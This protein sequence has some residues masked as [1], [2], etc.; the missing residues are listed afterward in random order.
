[1]EKIK[2]LAGE[3]GLDYCNDCPFLAFNKKKKQF[4]CCP[5]TYFF[6]KKDEDEF[7]RYEVPMWCG[8]RKNNF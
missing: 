2:S 5:N 4:E 8:N 3:W 7:G 1:M 6:D